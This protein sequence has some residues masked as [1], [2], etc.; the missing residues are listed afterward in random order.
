M[1][2]RHGP[3]A[4][5]PQSTGR[6]SFATACCISFCARA[7]GGNSGGVEDAAL[8][9]RCYLESL[10]ANPMAPVTYVLLLLTYLPRSWQDR[11][12]GWKHR[13]TGWLRFGSFRMVSWNGIPP[14][15][16]PEPGTERVS[17]SRHSVPFGVVSADR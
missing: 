11:L 8:A 1:R 17:I 6:R 12:A 14:A 13:L 10:A 5:S 2:D 15:S 3:R 4:V 16:N 7:A 9:R